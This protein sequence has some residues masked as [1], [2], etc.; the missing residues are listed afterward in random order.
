MAKPI[1]MSVKP[2]PEVFEWID[3]PINQALKAKS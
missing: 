3:F 2:E 1:A